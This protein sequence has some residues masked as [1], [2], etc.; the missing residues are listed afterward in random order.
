MTPLPTGTDA[1]GKKR[2]DRRLKA[3]II[4]PVGATIVLA[5]GEFAFCGA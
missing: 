4:A 3:G 1:L 5:V 2:R